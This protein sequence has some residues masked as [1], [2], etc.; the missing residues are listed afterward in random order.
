MVRSPAEHIVIY[1]FPHLFVRG[2]MPHASHDSGQ[3][4]TKKE[5]VNQ[6]CQEDELTTFRDYCLQEIKLLR[7][8]GPKSHHDGWLP[9]Q[10]LVG[11]LSGLCDLTWSC[12]TQFPPCLLETLHVSIPQCRLH[13]MAFSLSSLFYNANQ[14]NDIE[15]YDY[16]LATS[17]CLSSILV[18]VS[19]NTHGTTDYNSDE[20]IEL[21]TGL[22]PNLVNV[23]LI[24]P[25]PELAYV[26]SRT[27]SGSHTLVISHP[28]P[29]VRPQ[30]RGFF[31]N[32][33][34]RVGGSIK[35]QLRDLSLSLP[36][37]HGDFIDAWKA[38]MPSPSCGFN[39]CGVYR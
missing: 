22:T 24:F 11:Q 18:P 32:R 23:H 28:I 15:A 20:A 30:W 9:L 25:G 29:P 31:P 2:E 8:S 3:I 16:E 4:K 35:G 21:A 27:R 5:D 19:R 10:T 38:Q 36:V 33:P 7:R 14:P 13:T 26:P 37:P 39:V 34:N 6:G 12:V 1:V 17:P